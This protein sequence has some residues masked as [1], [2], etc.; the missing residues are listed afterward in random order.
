MALAATSSLL[1]CKRI[2]PNYT[3]F[4]L[5]VILDRIRPD[6]PLVPKAMSSSLKNQMKVDVCAEPTILKSA[7]RLFNQVAFLGSAKPTPI[8]SG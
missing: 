2:P 6:L 5:R 3:M 7:S 1:F 8:G 4:L